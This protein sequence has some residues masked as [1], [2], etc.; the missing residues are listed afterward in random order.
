M[1]SLI[2]MIG[3]ATDVRTIYLVS[4]DA[5]VHRH[6]YFG[7][8][9]EGLISANYDEIWTEHGAVAGADGFFELGTDIQRREPHEMAPNKRA[10]YRRRYELMD[11]LRMDVESA[12][13]TRGVV[14]AV[15]SSRDESVE[16]GV[17][18]A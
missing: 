4:D 16:N 18:V 10:M 6:R 1:V 12:V 8:R 13:S 9:H 11:A 17:V 15:Q 3:A 5:R 7:G 2:Q 14:S